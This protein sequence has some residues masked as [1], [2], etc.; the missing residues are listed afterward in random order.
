MNNYETI[1]NKKTAVH[2][3]TAAFVENPLLFV[4]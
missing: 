1:S 3:C 2:C 4:C